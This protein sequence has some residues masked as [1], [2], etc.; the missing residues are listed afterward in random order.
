MN[1]TKL[2]L[3]QFRAGYNLPV[4]A[5][6]AKGIFERHGLDIEV[7]YTPGSLYISEALRKGEIEIGHTG[8]D[9]IVAD[10]EH[11]GGGPGGLFIFMGLH[12]GLLSI[13]GAPGKTTVDALRGQELAVDARA[14]GLFLFW[15]N[16]CVLAD[17]V[18]A[19]TNLS[20][21]GASISVIRHS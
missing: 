11:S 15:K 14:S 6:R 17:L 3:I 16:S 7:I 4:H 20:K 8:A 18:L 13:V 2:R 21:S 19:T 5:G 1:L 9:D 10:V 12:S